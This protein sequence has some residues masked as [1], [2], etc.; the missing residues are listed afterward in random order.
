MTS[1]ITRAHRLYTVV[2]FIVLASLDNVAIGLVPPL[3]TPISQQFGVGEG[4]IAAVTA[5]TYLVSAFA[6][7]AWAYAG[8]RANRKPLLMV[9]TLIWAAGTLATAVGAE[10][11]PLPR[12]PDR[13]RGRAGRGRLGRLLGRQRPDQPAA[14]GAGDELL[15][16]VP[17]RRHCSPARWSAACSARPTGAGRST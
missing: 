4:A 17:G 1:A 11:R 3:Y 16:A 13:R 6:S 10:L 5:A 14:A 7:V 12:R 15:G 2:V 9:G 8:D